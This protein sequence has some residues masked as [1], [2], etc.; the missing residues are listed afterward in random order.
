VR[1]WR[2]AE[3]EGRDQALVVEHELVE[4]ALKVVGGRLQLGERE[5]QRLRLQHDAVERG[6]MQ[7]G[8]GHVAQL[9]EPARAA[10]VEAGAHRR[11][12]VAAQ[13]GVLD[14]L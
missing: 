4:R 3:D 10:C 8:D 6:Q 14:R 5:L 11:R 1:V 7:E 2:Q 12:E 9:G 13:A